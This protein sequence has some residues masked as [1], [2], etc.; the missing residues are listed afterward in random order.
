MLI[1][2]FGGQITSYIL[3]YTFSIYCLKNSALCSQGTEGRAKP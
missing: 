3:I 2:T 1:Y